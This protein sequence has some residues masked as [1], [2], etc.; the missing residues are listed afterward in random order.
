MTTLN[1]PPSLETLRSLISC[2]QGD[3]HSSILFREDNFRYN[4]STVSYQQFIGNDYPKVLILLNEQILRN[5]IRVNGQILPDKELQYSILENI[6][7]HLRDNGDIQPQ[8]FDQWLND[9]YPTEQNYH[10]LLTLVAVRWWL[11]MNLTYKRGQNQIISDLRALWVPESNLSNRLNVIFAE[12]PAPLERK[13]S[14]VPVEFTAEYM[15]RVCGLQIA[16]VDFIDDHLRLTTAK[17]GNRLVKTLHLFSHVPIAR[18][19][20]SDR[21]M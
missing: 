3:R 14:R 17:S 5:R 13:D 20:Y 2:L 21:R 11:A 7:H 10:G 4:Q 18:L 1:E 9:T 6:V 19:W 8:N 16:W 12:H 15:Y